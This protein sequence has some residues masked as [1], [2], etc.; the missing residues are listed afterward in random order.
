MDNTQ[1]LLKELFWGILWTPPLGGR[2]LEATS[3]IYFP[4]LLLASKRAVPLTHLRLY[5]EEILCE[6]QIQVLLHY[7]R[8]L[9]ERGIVHPFWLQQSNMIKIP[10]KIT[11]LALHI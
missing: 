1:I 2:R 4:G 5:Q 7:M 8:D 6:I 11:L 3:L 9:S 10:I